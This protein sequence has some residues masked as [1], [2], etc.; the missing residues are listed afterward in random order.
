MS[1]CPISWIGR[2][3]TVK[4]VL[5]PKVFYKMQM[6]PIPLGQT[7]F[8]ILTGL[9]SRFVWNNKK[10]W[11][12]FTVLSKEKAQGG[13]AIPD[14]KKYYYAIVLS[15]ALDWA[16]EGPNKR[17]VNLE[18]G[19][20]N[21]QLNHLIWNPPHYRNLGPNTHDIT[22]HIVKIW[23]Q[24]HSHNKWE[25]NSPLIYL[26]DNEFFPP[27]TEAVG[28]NWIKNRESQLKDITKKGKIITFQELSE[29]TG[30]MKVHVWRYGQLSHFVKSLPGSIRDEKNYRPLEKLF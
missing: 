19:L 17:R 30:L 10:P 24:I 25:Y 20:S 3:N 9:I 6:L 27:G 11:I 2:V 28:G 15:W 22:L 29:L 14:F 23:D 5:A 18:M 4:M 26:K 1:Y 21:A 12:A 16:K 7:Y 13:L 8:R